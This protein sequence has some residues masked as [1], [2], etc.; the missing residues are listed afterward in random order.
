VV[1]W[2]IAEPQGTKNGGGASTASWPFF[3]FIAQQDHFCPR[4]TQISQINF[5]FVYFVKFVAVF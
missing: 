5:F 3:Y 2:G 1:F 4:M